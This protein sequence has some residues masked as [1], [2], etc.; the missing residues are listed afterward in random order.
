[1][2]LSK[3]IVI[4]QGKT[5]SQVI[6][7]E[8]Q[9]IVYKAITGIAKTAP[10]RITCTGHGI[11][12]GWRVAVV[13]VKGMTQINAQNS[14]PKDK[15]YHPATIIGNDTV[16]LNDVN[17]ADMSTYTSGG[18]LQF[19]TPVSLTG[20][21]ARMKIKDKIGG[22]T[23]LLLDTEGTLDPLVAPRIV[24]DVAN[25]KINLSLTATDTAALTW[26]KGVYDLELVSNTGVVTALMAGSISVVKEVTTTT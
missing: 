20:Y 4:E 14:P 2:A 16:D 17:S 6:R 26:T 10:A 23:L 24:I 1:M 15:D 3:D 19:N 13:S 8:A 21:T 11:P 18:Y 12:P 9:P 22:T 5:Y 25:Y 7:W